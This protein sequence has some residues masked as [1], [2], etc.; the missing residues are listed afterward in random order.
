MRINFFSSIF[1]LVLVISLIKS[2]TLADRI[3]ANSKGLKTVATTSMLINNAVANSPEH[4]TSGETHSSD[5]NT[6]TPLPDPI[7]EQKAHIDVDN[8]LE[9]KFNSDEIKLL[10]E[11]SK[12]REALDTY[13]NQLDLKDSMLKATEDKLN[14]KI[15]ELQNLQTKVNNLL[16]QFEEK[17]NIRIKSLAKIYENMKPAEAAKIF[18]ELEMPLLLDIIKN[19]K[20]AKVAQIIANMNPIKAKEISLEFS[21]ISSENINSN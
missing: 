1:T 6:K 2:I 18:D 5:K 15:V 14:V 3:I 19:M 16:K 12:R 8:L 9:F 13:K 11:L 20:E 10:K 17:S 7:K 4:S 21:K